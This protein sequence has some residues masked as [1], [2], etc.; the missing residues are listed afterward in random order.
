MPGIFRSLFSVCL[1]LSL[2]ACDEEVVEDKGEVTRAIKYAKL[3]QRAGLQARRIAGVVTAAITS[4]VAFETG[5]QVVELLRKSGDRVEAGELIARL[6]PEPYSLQV[7]QAENSLAQAIATLD[8]S[9]KKFAQ[10]KRLLDQGFTTRTSFDSAEAALKNAEGAVGVAQS[11]LDLAKRELKKTDL[12]APFAGVIARQSVEVF[13]EVSGGQAIYS[14]QTDGEDKIEAA[15]PETMIN[16]VSLGATVEVSFPPLGGVTVTGKVDEIA[17]LT[18]DANAYPIEVSVEN[19]P[20]GLRSG[21]SAELTFRFATETT[22]KAFLVPLAAVKPSLGDE[23]DATIFVFN[24]ENKTLDE[25]IVTITNVEDNAL[26]IVGKLEEG[27]IIATAGVS[28]LHN[29]MRVALFDPER[30]R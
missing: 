2:A 14:M 19:A 6:D 22:G 17:P 7:S 4:S 29:G 12:K 23:G 13:E 3:D 27:E 1:I 11:Q 30:L 28:F 15:L 18:G 26:E 5:G 25:R 16:A 24:P 10:Q 20:P 8:D 21:M 9:Q